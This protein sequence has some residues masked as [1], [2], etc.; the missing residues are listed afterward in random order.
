MSKV[1]KLGSSTKKEKIKLAAYGKLKK[2]LFKAV[3]DYVR[4]RDNWTCITCGTKG[5]KSNIQ[6]G[7]YIERSY[8][9]T[10]FDERNNNA[11]CQKCN[12]WKDGNIRVYAV[13]LEEKYG[14]GILQELEHLKVSN[15]GKKMSR[16]V[17]L[18]KIEYF[19][20]KLSELKD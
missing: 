11:Q 17:M 1:P 7:H 5:D 14:A 3:S 16:L 8:I 9:G 6:C 2:E 19:K 12:C 10:A 18:E 13:K 20:K 4:E 15:Q